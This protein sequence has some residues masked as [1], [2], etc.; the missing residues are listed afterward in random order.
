MSRLKLVMLTIAALVAVSAVGSASASAAACKAKGEK[1]VYCSGG[2]VIES[3]ASVEATVGASTLKSLNAKKEV[4][5][6][7]TCTGGSA[8]GTV[9]GATSTATIAYTGCAVVKPSTCTTTATLT[10]KAITDAL[11]NTSPPEDTFTG[12]GVSEEYIEIELKGAS[13]ALKGKHPVTGKQTCALDG[14][15]LATIEK[16]Q[17]THTL[18]C[19][20]TGS[21][22]KFGAE[23]ATYSGTST[24]KLASK[25]A[26][27]VQKN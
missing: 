8:T 19:A 11:T 14:G 3:A 23:E 1:F 9:T 6:E 15:V 21:K 2:A 16:E 27:S 20:A 17:E 25:A 4:T 22:L 24:Q 10:T 13:C 18:N 26:W 5:V 12:A 7:I